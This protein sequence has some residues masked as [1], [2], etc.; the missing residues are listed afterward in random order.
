LVIPEFLNTIEQSGLSTWLRASPSLLAY[1]TVLTL[2]A[3]GQALLAGTSVAIDLRLLGV[4]P[5]IPLAPLERFFKV[6]WLGFWVNA[7]TGTVLLI[8]YPTKAFTD[9][10]FYVKMGFVAAAMVCLQLIRNRVFG[11]VNPA[12]GPMAANAK[13]LAAVSILC[14][15]GANFAGKFME[16]TYRHLIFGA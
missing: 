2:H 1:P 9:P 5:Q 6:M 12:Q 10:V 16:Y 7:L 4:A 15:F 13:N 3:F 11:H 8:T 14:W